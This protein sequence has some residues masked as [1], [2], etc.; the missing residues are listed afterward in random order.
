[1]TSIVRL[2]P[3]MQ[4]RASRLTRNW[5]AEGDSITAWGADGYADR[6]SV[7]MS[8]LPDVYNNLAVG[9]SL[10]STMSARAAATD[11]KI[12]SHARNVLSV[13]IG[14]NDDDPDTTFLTNLAAY[15]DARRAA[16]WY[17]I[18]MTL[19]PNIAGLTNRAIANPEIRLW[20]TSG[21]IVPGKHIDAYC[22]FAA[23]SI[24]GPDG[25]RSNTTYY[26]GAGV[27][28][29]DFSL[30]SPNGHERLLVWSLASLNA[31]FVGY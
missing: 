8:P 2:P 6:T 12:L 16:G 10:L 28:P 31:A 19:L 17:V 29:T 13:F 7:N 26:D 23:D 15:C 21:S 11:A 27:H 5:V 4:F 18:L 9:G 24:M 22:D 1:M 30:G 20:A 25:A 14:T 3:A